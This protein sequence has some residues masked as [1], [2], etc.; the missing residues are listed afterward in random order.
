MFILDLAILAILLIYAPSEKQVWES[1]RIGCSKM[2]VHDDGSLT[3]SL[4]SKK[5]ETPQY[6]N[7][8]ECPIRKG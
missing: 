2:V 6:C 1:G 8:S 4:L 3:C 7:Y 5:R